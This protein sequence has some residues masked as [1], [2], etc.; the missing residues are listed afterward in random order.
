M[1]LSTFQYHK[2]DFKHQTHASKY[3]PWSKIVL[4]KP[5]G[6]SYQSIFITGLID[7]SIVVGL[8]LRDDYKPYYHLAYCIG[9]YWI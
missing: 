2:N 5:L 1:D 8:P 3:V 7:T 9:I 4:D 6:D